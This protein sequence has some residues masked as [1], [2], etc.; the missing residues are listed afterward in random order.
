M[1]L[2][3]VLCLGGLLFAQGPQQFEATTLTGTAR[4]H[5]GGWDADSIHVE[6]VGRNRPS[7]P[8]GNIETPA[9]LNRFSPFHGT[10]GSQRGFYD[11]IRYTE[12]YAGIDLEFRLVDGS[13]KSE[14]DLRPGARADRISWRYKK[15]TALRVLPGGVLEATTP[16]GRVRESRL[17]AWQDFDDRRV[18]V[19]ASFEI[20][21]D[22][23]VGVLLGPYD[24]RLPLV[25]DPVLTFSGTAGGAGTDVITGV[26]RDA[27]GNI[28]FAGWTDSP[29]FSTVLSAFPRGGGVDAFV[30]KV[31][32]SSKSVVYLAYLGG[33]GDDRALGVAVDG[34]GYV[35]VCGSTNSSNFPVLNAHQ[36]TL[37]GGTNAFL[38]KLDQ[39]GQKI[40][41]STYFGGSGSTV[42]NAIALDGSGGVYIAGQTDSA[43]LPTLGPFQSANGGGVD[44]YIAKFTT[45]GAP[46]YASYLGGSGTDMAFAL[47]A[48]TSGNAYVTGSTSSVNFPV[49]NPL[50]SKLNGFADAFVTKVNAAGNATV[51]STYLGGSGGGI[52]QPE[53]G[54]AIAVDSQGNAYV[55]GETSSADF[56]VVNAYQPQFNG[57]NT[58]AFVA[59]LNPAGSQLV[60]STYLG[61]TDIDVANAVEIDSAGYVYVAGYTGSPD[62]PTVQRMQ[63]G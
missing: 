56:P 19:W 44:A 57:W 11:S 28:Y 41:F 18:T 59:K 37:N 4:F 29:A 20:W 26:A 49:L 21:R 33:S 51:Y 16:E 53:Q 15:G 40:L 45:T 10:D 60:F 31:N 27:S 9:W 43:S 30:M 32:G 47:A 14:F 13:L 12:L 36:A 2:L 5:E 62:F 61:G 39:A 55:A 8:S 17:I 23:T 34:D 38:A 7:W 6:Y 63:A 22:D 46:Q 54:N 52:G 58:D 48:D 24:K 42:A 1:R 3:A 25:I 50:Q 35:Y